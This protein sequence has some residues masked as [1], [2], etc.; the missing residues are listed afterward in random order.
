MFNEGFYQFRAFYFVFITKKHKWAYFLFGWGMAEV[1]PESCQISKM[2]LLAHIISS[3][4][5]L[6]IFKKS[7]IL[8]FNRVLNT[9]LYVPLVFLS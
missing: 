9:P 1:Y 5:P 8:D 2:E 3:F 7:S 6:T 4:Q